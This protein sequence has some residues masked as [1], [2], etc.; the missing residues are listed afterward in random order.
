MLTLHSSINTAE[1]S[2][3][4]DSVTL[5]PLACSSTRQV[6][7]AQVL[8]SSQVTPMQELL[9]R[10]RPLTP[11]V[12]TRNS[13]NLTT[14]IHGELSIR[15]CIST[16]RLIT[17]IAV[18]LECSV[19]FPFL[20]LCLYRVLSGDFFFVFMHGFKVEGTSSEIVAYLSGNHTMQASTQQNDLFTKPRIAT[21][22]HVSIP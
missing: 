13:P 21:L 15:S 7:T 5:F 9:V 14:A 19:H 20:V 11:T 22:S 16:K 17:A 4:E 18:K 6:S 10:S 2:A 8:G 1:L 12:A 3:I